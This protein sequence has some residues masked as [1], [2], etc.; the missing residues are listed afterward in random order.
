MKGIDRNG[1]LLRYAATPITYASTGAVSDN[2]DQILREKE[3]RH[4]VKRTYPQKLSSPIPSVESFSPCYSYG[5]VFLD[6]SEFCSVPE[7]VSF[8][9][10]TS[11]V[12]DETRTISLRLWTYMAAAIYLNGELVLE[13]EVPVYK[14][15]KHRDA[16]ITLEKGMNTILIRCSNIGIRDTYDIFALQIRSG[17]T[18]LECV[19]PTEAMNDE[20]A[21]VTEYLDS[22]RLE[23]TTLILP[24]PGDEDTY[25]E[26]PKE[27]DEY[28]PS[29]IPERISLSGLSSF[30]IKEHE[31][32]TLTKKGLSRTFQVAANA[33][34][35]INDIEDDGER[36]HEILRRIS[37]VRTLD[38]GDHG[39]SVF[40]V[41]A[42]RKLGIMSEEDEKLLLLDLDHVERRVDC[43]DFIIAGLIRY[44]QVYGFTNETEERFRA[45]MLSFR[46]WMDMK[47]QDGMCF[48]SENHS[49]MFY[50]SAYM[51]GRLYPDCVFDK[52]EK[53]G[54]E[55]SLDAEMRLDEWLD[56]V[57]SEGFEE[58]QSAIYM[59]VT[60]AAL[61]NVY[62]FAEE[63]FA[64]KAGIILD[65]LVRQL[66]IH[67][68][69]STVITPMGR[70]Y[71]DCIQPWR[72]GTNSVLSLFAPGL[73]YDFSEGWT[74][75]YATS[76]YRPSFD[77][78]K[79]MEMDEDTS[80]TTGNARII[81]RKT[82][83]W[84]LTSLDIPRRDKFSRW[85]NVS[86]SGNAD[87]R[88]HSY[89]KSI[90]ER[91]HGTSCFYPGARGYQQHTFYAAL[92]REALLF[93]N[94]PG[95]SSE[96]TG[97]RP[98]YWYGNALLPALFQDNDTLMGIFCL[99]DE[100]PIRFVHAY[101]PEE[102]FD[103]VR[104]DG[105]WIFLRKGAAYMAYWT[106][107][108]GERHDDMLSGAELR[109][110]APDLGFAVKMGDEESYSS[111][112]GFIRSAKQYTPEYEFP[113]LTL[114]DK[115][116]RFE[117][118]DDPSQVIE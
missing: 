34:P 38:R 40:N 19:F 55:M 44:R 10:A 58:F 114:K 30:E 37:R 73:S 16:E 13:N 21:P 2:P 117:K 79:L 52:A 98:G 113:C 39:F 7:G 15:I 47:G 50:F 101:L 78:K 87:I 111:F 1:Y 92:S 3:M 42:R 53:T 106:S 116:L 51:A 86:L 95:S 12:S 70:V 18:G 35:E 20:F 109:Y 45:V 26:Y 43:S 28:L 97:L 89:T 36:Y 14:P 59:C 74:V 108:K 88:R 63:K 80:D 64:R 66:A 96:K 100:V 17:F 23:N 48:W 68:F 56:D 25:I 103:E 71:R 115:T 84:I 82:P 112:E 54:R 27:G 107:I 83:S 85:E 22:A 62:D 6:R 9:A 67:V 5:S 93:L 76:G 104:R 118:T 90:N 77:V 75:F 69:D 8:D 81:V 33:R 91:F 11:I 4:G 99:D 46:F 31:Y 24:S 29:Y 94:H 60:F 72:A 65:R 32:F 49:L 105:N 57:I 102:K 41:L 110:H 61:L